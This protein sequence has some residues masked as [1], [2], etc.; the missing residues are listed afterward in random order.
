M[1]CCQVAVV[2]V[3]Q[4]VDAG[5]LPY[6][7]SSDP[8]TPTE[9]CIIAFLMTRLDTFMLLEL[10]LLVDLTMIQQHQAS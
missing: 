10:K 8:P 1:P 9:L 5:S 6:K 4:H 2:A 3:M 7:E